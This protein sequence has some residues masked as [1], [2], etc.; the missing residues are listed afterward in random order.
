MSS[1]EHG[2]LRPDLP[3]D[4]PWRTEDG[5]QSATSRPVRRAHPGARYTTLTTIPKKGGKFV[6][7]WFGLLGGS[8]V[9]RVFFE[10]RYL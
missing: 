2:R 3:I 8:V 5:P 7:D 4:G 6:R 1:V 10:L 9:V